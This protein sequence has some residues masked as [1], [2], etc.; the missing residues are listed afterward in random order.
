[1]LV[2]INVTAY[3]LILCELSIDRPAAGDVG[4]VAAV[5]GAHVK[6]HHVPVT[7]GLVIGGPGVTVV[8]HSS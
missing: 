6:Q 5:L 4:A 8:E 3:L 2:P 7:D 1:M